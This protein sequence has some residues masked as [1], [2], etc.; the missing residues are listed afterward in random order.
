MGTATFTSVTS[1]TTEIRSMPYNVA[2][3]SA[4]SAPRVVLLLP[5][6]GA[7]PLAAPGVDP[8]VAPLP[9]AAPADASLPAIPLT[10][11]AVAPLATVSAVCLTAS[12]V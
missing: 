11:D 5:T 9:S 4:S 7:G 8:L 12:V 3:S 1:P 6:T 10:A 2:I